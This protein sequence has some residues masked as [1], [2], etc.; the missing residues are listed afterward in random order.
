VY[1][2]AWKDGLPHGLGAVIY[3]GG[4]D[5]NDDGGGRHVRNRRAKNLTAYIGEWHLLTSVY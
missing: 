5:D 1:L 3:G 4:D 2:G